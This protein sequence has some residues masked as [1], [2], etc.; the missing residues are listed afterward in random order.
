MRYNIQFSGTKVALLP[1]FT[2]PHIS[3]HKPSQ[4]ASPGLTAARLSLK[5][6]REGQGVT[7][8]KRRVACQLDKLG[9]ERAG[10]V[11]RVQPL[12]RKLRVWVFL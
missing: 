1:P 11:Q 6:K 9:W 10:S 7:A 4:S 8:V 12:E 5:V 2:G 3:A